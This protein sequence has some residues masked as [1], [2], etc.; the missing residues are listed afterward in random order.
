MISALEIVANGVVTV[1]ILLAGRNSF[2]TW[3]TGILGCVLFAAVFFQAKLYA[4]VV[5]QLFFLVTSALGWW[6]WQRGSQGQPLKISN[7]GISMLTWAVPVGIVA[8]VFYGGLL[9]FFTDAYA[10]FVDSA[11]LVFSVIA[12]LLLMKRRIE[13]WAFWLLVN[14]IAIPLYA[15]RELY[16]TSILYS[17][18]WINAVV[19]WFWWRRLMLQPAI[20][21]ETA[22]SV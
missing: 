7:V 8:T 10:P 21:Y 6:Q 15:S 2:H 20:P 9:H 5:L 18:Y 11:V 17:V 12:Q 4:D 1:S 22:E 16:L 19:S 13:T 3:W 14:S